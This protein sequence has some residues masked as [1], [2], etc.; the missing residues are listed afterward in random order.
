MQQSQEGSQG[1]AS[2]PGI[3]WEVVKNKKY[4]SGNLAIVS[5]LYSIKVYGT[6]G[7]ITFGDDPVRSLLL[8]INISV[9]C[10]LL[11]K[12]VSIEILDGI[13][14]S[15][16]TSKKKSYASRLQDLCKHFDSSFGI[17]LPPSIKRSFADE[18]DEAARLLRSSFSI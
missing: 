12:A 11:N 15:K 17:S 5:C 2:P 14:F 7:V 16:F 1:N 3:H 6:S 4:S 8:R 13:S 9:D 10:V 18:F